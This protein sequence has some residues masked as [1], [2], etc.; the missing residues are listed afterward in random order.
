MMKKFI[1]L[2]VFCMVMGMT[3]VSCSKADDPSQSDKK[4]SGAVEETAKLSDFGGMRLTEIAD[5]AK[6]VY[7]DKGALVET[8]DGYST[9][10]IDYK[11]GTVTFEEEGFSQENH[12]KVDKQGRLT[13]LTFSGEDEGGDLEYRFK[14]NDAGHLVQ[15]TYHSE[16]SEDRWAHDLTVDYMWDGDLLVKITETEKETQGDRVESSTKVSTLSYEA[17]PD[18]KYMQ[19]SAVLVSYME[20]DSSFGGVACV[21]LLGKGPS[22]YPTAISYSYEDSTEASKGIKYTLNS[23]GL[24]EKEEV[25]HEEGG[26][27][28]DAYTYRY[29]KN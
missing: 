12:F 5:H 23:E 18:N 16:S 26:S 28:V 7:N 11:K 6:F 13:S 21:G 1:T 24:L 3:V 22:K 17:A 9:V 25:R 15:Q 10:K 19:Y 29:T 14:Y 20:L 8:S 4:P 27:Y 2:A